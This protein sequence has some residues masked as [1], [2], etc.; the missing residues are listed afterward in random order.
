MGDDEVTGKARPLRFGVVA[1]SGLIYL[2][3]E[4]RCAVLP[5]AVTRHF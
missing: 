3:G 1:L 5:I 2:S 4:I